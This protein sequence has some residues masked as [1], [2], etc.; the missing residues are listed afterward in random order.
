MREFVVGT[1]GINLKPFTSSD[2]RSAVRSNKSFGVLVL[3]LKSNSYRWR[4]VPDEPDGFT[5]DGK[6]HCRT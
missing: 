6:G 4:F 2:P 1:G 3:E 5:D